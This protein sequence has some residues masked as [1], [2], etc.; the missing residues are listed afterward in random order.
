MAH[1]QVLSS[2]PTKIT[3]S[4]IVHTGPCVFRG[5]LLGTDGVNDPVITVYDGLTNAGHEIVPTCTYDASTLGLNGVT[6]ITPG[7]Y[8]EHGIYIEVTCAGTVEVVPH[9]VPYHPD[10]VLKWP[11]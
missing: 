10:G 4:A 5:L 3:E 2:G 7:V 1:N 9:Y 11:G 8:C 6:G